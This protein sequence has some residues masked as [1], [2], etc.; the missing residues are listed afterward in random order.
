[1]VL[2]YFKDKK[3]EQLSVFVHVRVKPVT[4]LLRSATA[5]I[6][7]QN[8][9]IGSTVNIHVNQQL[10]SLSNLMWT[11]SLLTSRSLK[12]AKQFPNTLKSH[13]NNKL[14]SRFTLLFYLVQP[15]LTSAPSGS[16]KVQKGTKRFLKITTYILFEQTWKKWKKKSPT[17]NEFSPISLH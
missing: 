3:T 4:D 9:W 1:M 8:Y 15:L 14:M 2:K 12:T 5:F 6:W 11:K 16:R 7:K 17:L 13:V 10:K